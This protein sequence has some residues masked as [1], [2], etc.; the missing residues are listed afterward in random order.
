MGIKDKIKEMAVDQAIDQMCALAESG[1]DEDLI[2]IVEI[3]ARIT[4]NPLWSS[5]VEG[6]HHRLEIN[7]PQMHMARKFM[8]ELDPHVRRTIMR[9]LIANEALLGYQ[10]RYKVK[11][12]LGFYPPSHLV[13]S[14]TMA[15]NLSCFGCYASSYRAKGLDYEQ[16]KDILAQAKDL[17]MYLVIVSGGEPLYW[18]HFIRMC[19]EHPDMTFQF[20]T[21][22]TL[23]DRAMAKKL[24]ELGNVI[25]AISV[26]GFE[27][28]TD[29]RRGKG[30]YKKLTDAMAYLK[31]LGG[32][33]AFSCT[34]HH[35]NVDIVASDEFMDD[36]QERG[37]FYGWYFHYMPLGKGA[38][39]DL[40][41]TPEQ[42]GWLRK[43]IRQL[44]GTK[45]VFIA[46]F[47]NDGDYVDGCI[48][49]GK[50]YFHINS[51]GDIEPCV[52]CHFATHNIK[53]TT[54]KE[55]LGSPL[56]KAIR[57][58]QPYKLDRRQPCML[59][60]ANE[61][62]REVLEEAGDEVYWTHDGADSIITEF[63][64]FLED[65][66][67]R[68]AQWLAEH[69]DD[70]DIMEKNMEREYGHDPH[71]EEQIKRIYG[72][73]TEALSDEEKKEIYAG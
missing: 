52:F 32:L 36:L 66:S 20:Y 63:A 19:E 35:Y 65:L 6:F 10:I 34:A 50:H 13:I 40:M 15:C 48:A 69:N 8:R 3:A 26:E 33:F 38:T 22:A 56:F 55:A 46:D 5:A 45:G 71:R 17:G 42:R 12:E 31:E 25:P 47:W 27:Q 59:I 9:N 51:K 16:V 53:D 62:L 4:N 70:P 37:V 2:K 41:L 60:D 57:K 43:R 18:P 44:R 67:E 11:E 21:N 64:P 73:V 61:Q 14:P 23:I 7:H 30:T 1:N 39:T 68:Y 54:L 72:S 24:V 58:R 49:G 28:E 29:E